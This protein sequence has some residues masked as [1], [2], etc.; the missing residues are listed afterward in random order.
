MDT[1]LDSKV[2]HHRIDELLLSGAARTASEA[3]ALFLDSHLI[4]LARL[5]LVLDEQSFKEHE[6]VKLLLAH[7]SRPFEDSLL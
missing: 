4:D 2:V 7:G 1:H 5:A 3:E 6:A